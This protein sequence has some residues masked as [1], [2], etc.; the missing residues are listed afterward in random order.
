MDPANIL[1]PVS[2]QNMPKSR[3]KSEG[4]TPTA[5]KAAAAAVT[6][7]GI[8]AHSAAFFSTSPFFRWEITAEA[9]VGRK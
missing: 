9:D 1:T 4:S 8:A 3:R 6:V 2:T 7:P 5:K